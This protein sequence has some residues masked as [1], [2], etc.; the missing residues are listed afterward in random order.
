MGRPFRVAVG[1][2]PLVGQDEPQSLEQL[3]QDVYN[4]PEVFDQCTYSILD[5]TSPAAPP[6]RKSA[7]LHASLHDAETCL[8]QIGRIALR[9]SDARNDRSRTLLETVVDETWQQSKEGSAALVAQRKASLGSGEVLQG[10]KWLADVNRSISTDQASIISLDGGREFLLDD[11]VSELH[12][13]R[14]SA[15]WTERS[16][17]LYEN[18]TGLPQVYSTFPDRRRVENGAV[19]SPRYFL[20]SEVETVQSQQ[21]TQAGYETASK[22]TEWDTGFGET[23]LVCNWSPEC[24][25]VSSSR[26]DHSF[27][28]SGVSSLD[29]MSDEAISE[30]ASAWGNGVARIV[31]Q[32]SCQGTP[33]TSHASSAGVLSCYSRKI[34]R[35]SKH[36]EDVLSTFQL[37][38]MLCDA[39]DPECPILYAS[40]GFFHMTGYS[41]EEVV[42]RNCRFLQGAN[43][44]AKEVARIGVA[45]KKG[46]AYTGTLL[47]YKKDGSPFWNLLS[48]SPIR[49]DKGKLIKHIGMQADISSLPAMVDPRRNQLAIEGPWNKSMASR[50]IVC[51]HKGVNSRSSMRRSDREDSMAITVLSNSKVTATNDVQKITTESISNRYSL[52]IGKRQSIESHLERSNRSNHPSLNRESYLDEP[53]RSRLQSGLSGSQPLIWHLAAERSAEVDQLRPSLSFGDAEDIPQTVTQEAFDDTGGPTN[54]IGRAVIRVLRLFRHANM[55]RNRKIS[56]AS[57]QLQEASVPSRRYNMESTLTGSEIDDTER[58]QINITNRY[59]SDRRDLRCSAS[60]K[61]YMNFPRRFSSDWRKGAD[62]KAMPSSV[63]ERLRARNNLLQAHPTTVI[64]DG[65]RLNKTQFC[66][67]H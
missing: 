35:V 51:A 61:G 65:L 43:T 34:P 16:L 29:S 23:S 53:G 3:T 36:I 18:A 52:T 47:N 15:K 44:D 27:R 12:E 17:V 62:L 30:R 66:I 9:R 41:V 21:I 10:K 59:W 13:P 42:G 38:F 63:L 28:N 48:L 50:S 33:R 67:V 40:A 22:A 25:S 45:L 5:S 20:Q 6:F 31:L 7:A 60:S 49:D 39:I 58:Q 46:E 54:K 19:S 1:N 4:S 8:Q 57:H 24:Q 56:V 55:D 37:A 26:I 32:N 2:Q 11:S 64:S 14:S